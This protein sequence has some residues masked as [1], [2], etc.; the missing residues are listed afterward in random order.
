VLKRIHVNQ[1]IIR[2]NHRHSANDAP[3]TIKTYKANVRAH[4]VSIEGP[5]ELVY[6]PQDPLSCGA[7]LWIETDSRVI[8]YDDTIA[9]RV[10]IG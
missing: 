1:H 10:E 3:I 9:A 5:S 7:R 6:S 8:A 4:R 2:A